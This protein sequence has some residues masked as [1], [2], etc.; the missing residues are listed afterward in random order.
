MESEIGNKNE[1]NFTTKKGQKQF[2]VPFDTNKH[3]NT[4]N[5]IIKR[6]EAGHKIVSLSISNKG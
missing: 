5:M 4:L 6:A 1:S 3:T 2:P